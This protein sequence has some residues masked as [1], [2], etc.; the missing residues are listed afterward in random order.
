MLLYTLITHFCPLD[1]Q[2]TSI[3]DQLDVQ[4]TS[5]IGNAVS[6][7]HPLDINMADK[8][9]MR[10]QIQSGHQLDTCYNLRN[11]A[12]DAIWDPFGQFIDA[13]WTTFDVQWTT[14]ITN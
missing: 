5:E 12:M 13:H 3:S 4:R 7:G 10:R 2:W 6:N 8:M 1:I 11:T 9:D 14:Y